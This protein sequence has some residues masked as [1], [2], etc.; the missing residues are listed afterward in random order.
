MGKAIKIK[1]LA[2]AGWSADASCSVDTN[3]KGVIRPFFIEIDNFKY[4]LLFMFLMSKML[5]N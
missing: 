4:Y 2:L 3:K 1:R 5:D